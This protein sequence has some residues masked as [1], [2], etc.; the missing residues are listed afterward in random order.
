MPR[1]CFALTGEGIGY[2]VG[3]AAGS[4]TAT[5]SQIASC[6]GGPRAPRGPYAPEGSAI[7]STEGWH[8]T[9]MRRVAGQRRYLAAPGACDPQYSLRT[10][11]CAVPAVTYMQTHLDQAELDVI[12]AHN[13]VQA[14][15]V[16][17]DKDIDQWVL[18]RNGDHKFKPD[19]RWFKKSMMAAVDGCTAV[20]DIHWY[21]EPDTD[22]LYITEKALSRCGAPL[23]PVPTATYEAYGDDLFIVD[24]ADHA[25]WRNRDDKSPDGCFDQGRDYLHRTHQKSAYVVVLNSR[26]H[27]DD[28]LFDGGY[29]SYDVAEVKLNRDDTLSVHRQSGYMPQVSLEHCQPVNDG[30]HE[31]QGFVIADSMGVRAARP[32]HWMRCPAY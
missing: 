1:N 18:K 8:V 17:T 9:E 4:P 32:F 11:W 10:T 13:P 21:V 25:G 31:S 5:E 16:L 6:D 14:G 23:A 7:H 30:P 24:C 28:R 12:A 20:E 22:G 2:G 27:R 15:D 26:A 29:V 3:Q 19:G